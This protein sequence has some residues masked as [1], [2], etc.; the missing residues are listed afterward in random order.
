[1]LLVIAHRGYSEKYPENTLLALEAAIDE[2]GADGV[3]FDVHLTADGVLILQHD[4]SLDRMT[5]GHGLIAAQPW[6]GCLDRLL[7]KHDDFPGQPIATFAAALQSLLHKT[8]ENKNKFIVIIDVKDD[9]DMAVLDALARDLSALLP[10]AHNLEICV[11]CWCDE[12]TQHLRTLFPLPSSQI[13]F[14]WIG[15]E[16]TADRAA[17][18]LYDSFDVNIDLLSTAARQEALKQGKAVF[19]WTCNS[20]DQVEKAKQLQVTGILTDDPKMC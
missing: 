6:T 18:Q 3:E 5:T 17:C 14:T 12:F 9:Q 15:E 8:S 1:L 13:R 20:A 4:E 7:T 11:G 16:L 19:A 10:T 2:G